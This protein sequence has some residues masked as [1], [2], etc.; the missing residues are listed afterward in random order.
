MQSPLLATLTVPESVAVPRRRMGLL[1][2]LN[3]HLCASEGLPVVEVHD[4]VPVTSMFDYDPDAA[5]QLSELPY[6]ID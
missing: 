5:T 4:I 6:G 2:V 1:E 3:R